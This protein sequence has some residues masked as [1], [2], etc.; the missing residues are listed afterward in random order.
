MLWSCPPSCRSSSCKSLGQWGCRNTAYSAGIHDG[1]VIRIRNEYV[2]GHVQASCVL[3]NP[4]H[5]TGLSQRKMLLEF[6]SAGCSE[7]IWGRAR[8]RHATTKCSAGLR[9]HQRL[10]AHL[11]ITKWET[12]A[13]L[14]PQRSEVI[15]DT[16]STYVQFQK[17]HAASHCASLPNA[18]IQPCHPRF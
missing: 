12:T 4:Q 8:G 13:I 9:L 10:A 17:C 14:R 11:F 16:S 2:F 5:P 15:C 18:A 3:G 7:H 1:H 6:F